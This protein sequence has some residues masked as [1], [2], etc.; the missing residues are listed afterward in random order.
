MRPT[1]AGD[2]EAAKPHFSLQA[3]IF[4]ASTIGS[5]RV[6]LALTDKHRNLQQC[7]L[8]QNDIR[9]PATIIASSPQID[10]SLES[11]SIMKIE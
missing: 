6:H 3:I 2:G 9:K 11:F 4:S 7:I 5:Q 1:A 8:S 10:R